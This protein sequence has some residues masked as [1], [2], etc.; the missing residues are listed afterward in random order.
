MLIIV[1]I[2][3]YAERWKSE[4]DADHGEI[5]RKCA[6]VI[7]LMCKCYN[8]YLTTDC[9]EGH[10]SNRFAEKIRPLKRRNAM[11]IDVKTD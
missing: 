3:G 1:I 8:V 4:N 7:Q 6:Q 10:A 11:A 2:Y 5:A 9:L